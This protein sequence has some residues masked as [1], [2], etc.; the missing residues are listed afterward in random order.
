MNQE[1]PGQATRRRWGLPSKENWASI[2]FPTHISLRWLGCGL[3]LFTL[4][5]CGGLWWVPYAPPVLI[6][7]G[8]NLVSRRGIPFGD[9]YITADSGE[10]V[11]GWYNQR[12]GVP[13]ENNS[14][15]RPSGAGV[16]IGNRLFVD[17]PFT[18]KTLALGRLVFYNISPRGRGVQINISC[19]PTCNSPWPIE[20]R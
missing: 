19:R 6:Y 14:P 18:G 15:G 13:M 16:Q 7:P 8:A 9:D 12:L 11:K 3:L 1:E 4:L 20:I 2:R 5:G 10:M 17:L